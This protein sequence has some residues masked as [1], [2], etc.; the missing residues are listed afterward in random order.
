MKK[1]LIIS[2]LLLFVMNANSQTKKK[3]MPFKH[4][5]LWGVVDSTQNTIIKPKYKRIRILGDLDYVA[6][7][8]ELIFDLEKGT[9]QKSPGS[10]ITEIMVNNQRFYHFNNNKKSVLIDLKNNEKI[11]LSLHYINFENIT[12]LDP[13]SK[14]EN[15]YIVG[16][17][18]YD[19]YILLQNTKN[20]PAAIAGKF[21][22]PDL[23][24]DRSSNKNLYFTTTKNSKIYV[25][26]SNLK[27]VNTS[28]D[29]DKLQEN[30]PKLAK[31]ANS[32]EVRQRC[33]IC[34]E[35]MGQGAFSDDP[36]LPEIFDVSYKANRLLV[37]YKDKQGKEV[38]VRPYQ[39][40]EKGCGYLDG[41]TFGKNLLFIDYQ[42]V[43]P[44]T[45]MFPTEYLD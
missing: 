18:D 15:K 28:L 30:L 25:Y 34:A 3:Y 14:I 22:E 12:L 10:Y 37:V 17:L 39:T 33:F 29:E 43:T 16:K 8:N 20:L 42:Y 1:L 44:R 36:V 26:D 2:F 45:L 35:V 41:V 23:I 38:E 27:I 32:E 4:N 19:S 11:S 7:D 31:K 5:S 13:K 40:F 9:Q 21:A 6:L 24:F